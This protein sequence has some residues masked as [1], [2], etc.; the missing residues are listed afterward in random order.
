MPEHEVVTREQFWKDLGGIRD[1]AAE[2]ANTYGMPAQPPTDKKVHK[3]KTVIQKEGT[4][5]YASDVYPG[6]EGYHSPEMLKR[7]KEMSGKGVMTPKS[8]AADVPPDTNDQTQGEQPPALPQAGPLKPHVD[9]RGKE[10]PKKVTEKKAEYLALPSQGRYPLD[11]YTQ[12][13]KAAAYFGEWRKHFAPED[14]REFCTNLVKRASMLGIELSDDI[15]KYGAAGYA[16]GP[17]VAVAI[18]GRR[19]VILDEAHLEVLDKV[20]EMRPMMTPDDFC[21]V[22]GEFDKMAGIAHMYDVDILDPYFSTFGKEAAEETTIVIGND[23]V[24]EAELKAYAK[25][26][27][28]SLQS[29]WGEDFAKEFQKD[30]LGIFKSLPRD[31]K[32]MIIRMATDTAKSQ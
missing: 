4:A 15:Q 25:T 24:T 23:I 18:D 32:I 29:T 6:T 17:E 13:E 14:R 9:V 10:A 21:A 27:F 2:A 22:L 12:V 3:S 7:L 26:H 8:A 11:S 19:G 5:E 31:Q 28:D 1:K 20:A 30:P 16:P